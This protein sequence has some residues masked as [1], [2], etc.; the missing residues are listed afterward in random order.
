MKFWYKKF[1]IL[2]FCE[3]L[4][5]EL[6]EILVQ[7]IVNSEICAGTRKNFTSQLTIYNVYRKLKRE[8]SL[9]DILRIQNEQ[10]QHEAWI[11]AD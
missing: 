5:Q 3:I 7:E 1:E 8:L 9:E 11:C 2:K 4:V 6:C 10:M